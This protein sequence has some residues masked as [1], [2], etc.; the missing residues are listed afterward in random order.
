MKHY[1]AFLKGGLGKLMWRWKREKRS[2]AN[3][4]RVVSHLAKSSLQINSYTFEID[5][6][7]LYIEVNATGIIAKQREN[8]VKLL[9]T[10]DDTTI[11]ITLTQQYGSPN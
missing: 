11:Q 4:E 5:K 1:L 7:G 6:A 8:L 2:L 10:L 3:L 9:Q